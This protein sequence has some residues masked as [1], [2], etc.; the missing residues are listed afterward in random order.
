MEGVDE[1]AEGQHHLTDTQTEEMTQGDM[2]NLIFIILYDMHFTLVGVD[3]TPPGM[4][5]SVIQPNPPTSD[6]RD[7]C[8]LS[9]LNMN[10]APFI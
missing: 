8:N 5:V 9:S 1:L 2:R 3:V 4:S 6:L 7:L 10:V